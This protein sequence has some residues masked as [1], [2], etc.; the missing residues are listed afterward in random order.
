ME[1]ATD[2]VTSPVLPLP[3]FVPKVANTSEAVPY[4][5]S[6]ASL[7]RSAGSIICLE[8]DDAFADPLIFSS[9]LAPAVVLRARCLR[10][11][12]AVSPA[13]HLLN[14]ASYPVNSASAID[15]TWLA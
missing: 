15:S 2:S 6:L 8:H 7:C 4:R 11:S 13:A 9:P 3:P 5:L 14:C 10:V 1:Q 12:R